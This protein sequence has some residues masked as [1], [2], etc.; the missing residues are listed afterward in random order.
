MLGKA[1]ADYFPINLVFWISG[2]SREHP[3]EIFTT[4]YDLLL[5]EIM[6]RAEIPLFDE[7][8]KRLCSHSA[9]L[10]RLVWHRY[11]DWCFSHSQSG[12][13][14]N[15]RSKPLGKRC[16]YLERLLAPHLKEGLV[17]ILASTMKYTS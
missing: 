3:I 11:G 7:F 14:W 12:A 9:E 6:E 8:L 2:T 16:S 17:N 13:N 15:S 1:T 5:E 4:N 10:Q